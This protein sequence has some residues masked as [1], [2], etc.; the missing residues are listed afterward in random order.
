MLVVPGLSPL[1]I[2]DA[3]AKAY[4]RNVRAACAGDAR[5]LC[6]QHKLGSPD[7]GRCMESNGLSLSYRC[8]R[9]LEIA[10]VVPRG[11]SQLKAPNR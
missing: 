1:N 9:A 5:R 7:M 11:L 8:L 4:P 6:P 2:G 10:G 3:S